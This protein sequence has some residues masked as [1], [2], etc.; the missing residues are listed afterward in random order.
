MK[1]GILAFS[2]LLSSCTPSNYSS[3]FSD[4]ISS[5]EIDNLTQSVNDQ[6]T[7]HDTPSSVDTNI[8]YDYSVTIDNM[9]YEVLVAGR[10]SARACYTFNE[11]PMP[12]F[13]YPSNSNVLKEE[14]KTLYFDGTY[15]YSFDNSFRLSSIQAIADEPSYYEH[16][17]G[18]AIT[19][20]DD[21]Y[22]LFATIDKNIGD[23][24]SFL[25]KLDNNLNVVET[26]S[27]YGINDYSIWNEIAF[28]DEIY[29]FYT[30]DFSQFILNGY[31]YSFNEETNRL[32]TDYYLVLSQPTLSNGIYTY[33]ACKIDSDGFYYDPD[34]SFG[35][36]S[37]N[38]RFFPISFRQKSV[39]GLVESNGEINLF[40]EIGEIE[41]SLFVS[42][43][44]S[45]I[46]YLKIDNDSMVHR[47]FGR[48]SFYTGY[49]K[50]DG[51]NYFE[52]ATGTKH[53][54]CQKDSVKYYHF[55][56]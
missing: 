19:K 52:I 40:V 21:S 8:L 47:F 16:Y 39:R 13:G 54:Y 28:E 33:K 42:Y 29:A 45:A 15:L 30:D 43:A 2:L 17:I 37:Q 7:R 44:H 5:F 51:I 10:N 4:Y 9:K 11:V 27:I 1:K 26:T 38:T 6:Y 50:K 48:D 35:E 36:I 18:S 49:A 53:S 20:K 24:S 22:Y 14:D 41:G 34:H 31:V 55:P 56:V 23:S 46:D 3:P 32:T 25:Y 12:Y